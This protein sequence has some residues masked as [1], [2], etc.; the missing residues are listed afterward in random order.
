MDILPEIEFIS[1][2]S[3]LQRFLIKVSFFPVAVLPQKL[4]MSLLSPKLF[5]HILFSLIFYYTIP[6]LLF[7]YGM[8]GDQLVE[9]LTKQVRKLQES[10]LTD[11][12]C[13]FSTS[14]L[15]P[16]VQ[17]LPV[18]VSRGILS[19]PYEIV[20]AS[21]LEKPKNYKTIG[22]VVICNFISS[23][24]RNAVKIEKRKVWNFPHFL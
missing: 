18:I 21:D 19:A 7:L 23:S 6:A 2:W 11:F 17:L 20:M 14:L 16:M 22:F 10:N 4:T 15:I 12:L 3:R 9:I 24:L 5:F 8:D 1:R 13:Y